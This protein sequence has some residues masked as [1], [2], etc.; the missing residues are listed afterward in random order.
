V[1]VVRAGVFAF[2]LALIVATLS[3]AI[4]TLVLPRAIPSRMTRVVFQMVRI[5]FNIRARPSRP[6]AKRDITMSFYAPIALLVLL[7]TWLLCIVAGYAA[8]MGAVA[9]SSA[10][11]AI[12]LSGSSVF[13]LGTSSA[14]DLP[15]LLLAY[16]EA[17]VGPLM[18]ALLITYLPS[19]YTAFSRRE[20]TVASLEVWAGS[21]PS[22]LVCLERLLRIRGLDD[23]DSLWLRWNQW[24]VELQESHTTLPV[25]A[26]F[27]SPDPRHSW[28]TAA[29]ALLDTAAVVVSTLDRPNDPDAQLCLRAGW[30]SLRTVA[31]Y[32]RVDFDPDPAPG[33]PITI[34]REEFDHLV[35]RLAEVGAPI[36]ADREQA[37]RDYIGWRVNYDKALV[38]LAQVVMAPESP[39]S[40]DRELA[41]APRW[42]R[43]WSRPTPITYETGVVGG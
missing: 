41:A 15:S 20:A 1:I 22:P 43:T 10:R 27:R 37:W 39:W 35:N 26:F 6:W 9:Q 4:R 25:V 5:P 36:R 32:F 24:F 8:M 3:S 30:L 34:R 23:L 13:T 31:A 2:G 18:L 38:G 11:Q 19:M 40:S 21:P 33:D 17:G 14:G 16:T 42:W 7:A 28:V 29:G 12:E